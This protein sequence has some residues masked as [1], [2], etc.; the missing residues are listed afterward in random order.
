MI[1]LLLGFGRAGL[2]GFGGGPGMIPLLQEECVDR[3]GWLTEPEFLEVLAIGNGLPGPLA[4]KI[5]LFVGHKEEGALGAASAVIGV[6]AP[7]L[8]LMALLTGLYLRFRAHPALVGALTAVRPMVVGMLAWVTFSLVPSGITD[9]WGGLIA[10]AACAALALGVHPA[11][12]VAV[13]LGG[14]AAFLR[15]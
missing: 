15:G 2:F 13:A 1:D 12:V 10:V 7:A 5:A 4:L 9:I 14:G 11:V 8:L 3:A 6:S